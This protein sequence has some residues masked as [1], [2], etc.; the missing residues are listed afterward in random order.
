ML[1]L[2]VCSMG[3]GCWGVAPVPAVAAGAA[4]GV[5]VGAAAAA[6]LMTLAG[7]D[8]DLDRSASFLFLPGVALACWGVTRGPPLLLL[9]SCVVCSL[10]SLT[11]DATR[12][13]AALVLAAVLAAL[14]VA[15]LLPPAGV[16]DWLREG[17]LPVAGAAPCTTV[18]VRCLAV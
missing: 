3:C 4:A 8:W 7:G 12:L 13:E 18:T 2:A 5:A 17:C 15:G 1:G 9:D 14:P 6:G 16:V 11:L 10:L